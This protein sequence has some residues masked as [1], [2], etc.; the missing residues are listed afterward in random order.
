LENLEGDDEAA[1]VK[2][3][4]YEDLMKMYHKLIDNLFFKLKERDDSLIGIC[5]MLLPLLNPNELFNDWR[6]RN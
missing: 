1:F 6:V 3:R 4:N 2:Q 5:N